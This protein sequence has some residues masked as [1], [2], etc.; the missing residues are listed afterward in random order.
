MT[1]VPQC[2]AALSLRDGGGDLRAHQP[3]RRRRRAPWRRRTGRAASQGKRGEDATEGEAKKRAGLCVG[4]C[5]KIWDKMRIKLWG[6][7]ESKYFNRGIMIAILI[8][9]ISMGIEHHEQPEEL[10]NVLEICNIVFTS[11]FALEM[12]LK[13]TAF[14]CFCYPAQPLQHLRRHHL[15]VRSSGSQTGVCRVLRTFRLLRVLKLVRFMPALRRQLV[16]LMK[17]MDNVATLLH[18]PHALHLHIQHPGNAHLWVQIQPED[19]TRGTPSRTGRTL[20]PCCGP[21]S[22][23]SRS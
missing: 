11:M 7:V 16:V 10:T 15:C 8:N 12:V 21:S 23:C 5:K 6:I 17:T 13:L 9:T 2:T 22:L 18:A 4:R 1:G 20:T 19:G 3:M 14:G